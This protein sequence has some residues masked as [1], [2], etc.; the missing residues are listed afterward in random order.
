MRRLWPDVYLHTGAITQ[1]DGPSAPAGSGSVFNRGSD[2]YL[3]RR[4]ISADKHRFSSQ[5]SVDNTFVN[6]VIK[7]ATGSRRGR[8]SMFDIEEMIQEPL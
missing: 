2:S 8:S 7:A 6:V 1:N 3:S 5:Q 4:L